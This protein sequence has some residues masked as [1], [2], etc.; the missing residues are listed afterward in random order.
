MTSELR[1]V[2]VSRLHRLADDV[3]V[4]VIAQCGLPGTDEDTVAL[5]KDCYAAARIMLAEGRRAEGA[6]L[7][8]LGGAVAV[9]P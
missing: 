9:K 5:A 6:L 7:G 3:F 4:R 1:L 2:S 8:A